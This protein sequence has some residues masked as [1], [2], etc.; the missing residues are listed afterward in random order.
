MIKCIFTILLTLTCCLSKTD[1]M[2]TYTLHFSEEKRTELEKTLDHYQKKSEKLLTAQFLIENMPYHLSIDEYFLDQNSNK[3]R[4]DLSIIKENKI[5]QHFDSLFSKGHK[6]VREKRYD[7]ETLDSAYL[8]NNIELAF[9]VWDKKWARNTSFEDFCKY[10]LPYRVQAEKASNLRQ[11]F[12]DRYLPLLEMADPKTPLEACLIINQ[13]LMRTIQYDTSGGLGLYPSIEETYRTKKGICDDL[14]IL[15]IYI[16]RAVGIPVVMEQTTWVKGDRGHTWAAVLSNGKF[17]PFCPCSD[18]PRKYEWMFSERRMR[19]PAKVYRTHFEPVRT[20]NVKEDDGYV[21]YLK[22]PLLEDVTTEY[23]NQTINIT[24]TTDKKTEK[25]K[26]QV[27]LCA[28]NQQH[29][30]PF[31][32]GHRNGKNCSFENIV[33]DNVFIIADSPNGTN[34]RFIT[35]PF[36]VSPTGSIHKIIPD[37]SQKRNYTLKKLDGQREYSHTLQYWDTQSEQFVSLQQEQETDST[38]TYNEIPRNALLRFTIPIKCWDIRIFLIEND[39][40]KTY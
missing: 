22:S 24:V 18:Q 14:C 23:P 25:R 34:L 15:G 26:S 8:V 17:Y 2:Q 9:S 6:I 20:F 12:R 33:G 7:I 27:Y 21:T 19:K 37:K 31:A 28:Y 38:L 10:I 1:S 35:V 32:I 29:W 13:E 5:Q 11:Y 16:M 30:E 36:H 3:Y 4:P 40:V 39:S